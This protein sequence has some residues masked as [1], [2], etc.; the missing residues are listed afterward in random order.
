MRAGDEV[1]RYDGPWTDP[2][3]MQKLNGLLRFS[4]GSQTDGSSLTALA[5]SNHWHSTDQVPERAITSGLIGRFDSGDPTDGGNTSHYSLSGRIAQSDADGVWKANAFVIKS[6]LDLFNNFTYFL[7]DPTNGDQ[8]HQ[9]DNRVVA[10]ANASRLQ[11]GSLFE[12]AS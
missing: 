2:D 8:F 1:A 5:Y 10:G 6:E 9:H 11:K 12:F 4:S 3:G 7:S